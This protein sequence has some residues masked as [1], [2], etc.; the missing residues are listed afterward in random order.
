MERTFKIVNDSKVRWVQYDENGR[1]DRCTDIWEFF[2]YL[3]KDQEET[4]D[5]NVNMKDWISVGMKP[6]DYSVEDVLNLHILSTYVDEGEEYDDYVV[7]TEDRN[8]LNLCDVVIG[9]G[10]ENAENLMEYIDIDDELRN[11]FQSV[12]DFDRNGKFK[13]DD[14]DIINKARAIINFIETQKITFDDPYDDTLKNTVEM[15]NIGVTY[16]QME[17][18]VSKSLKFILKEMMWKLETDGK[19]FRQKLASEIGFSRLED[20]DQIMVSLTYEIQYGYHYIV[21][22]DHHMEETV[23][24]H[25]LYPSFLSRLLR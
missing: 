20:S 9:D 1:H 21:T 18:Y 15:L 12:I 25:R 22:I 3:K 16:S 13:I 19:Y 23:T 10:Y 11:V 6:G 5:Q 2:K 4:I 7:R 14:I 8:I 17:T 24:T